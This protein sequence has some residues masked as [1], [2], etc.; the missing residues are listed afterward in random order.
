MNS[1]NSLWEYMISS[2]W[3]LSKEEIVEQI[4]RLGK[5][6]WELVTSCSTGNGYGSYLLLFKRKLS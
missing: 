2:T 5:E 3:S 1:L 4:N 6:G